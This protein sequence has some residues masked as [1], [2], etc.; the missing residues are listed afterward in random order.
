MAR[1]IVFPLWCY[2]AL[3]GSFPLF[4][5]AS[6]AC[7]ET[8]NPCEKLFF[9]GS[10][11]RNGF[12]SNPFEKGC[13]QTL[14]NSPDDGSLS[15]ATRER[16]S[17]LIRR[18]KSQ[19]RVCNSYDPPEAAAQGLCISHSSSPIKNYRN[20]YKNEEDSPQSE[21]YADYKEI[22]VHSQNWESSFFSAWIIQI[23]LSEILQVPTTI[24]SGTLELSQQNNF[25]DPQA[26]LG[27][28]I[29]ND[30]D[31]F[32]HASEAEG[33][34][35]TK[36]QEDAEANGRGY[37]PCAHAVLEYWNGFYG[38]YQGSLQAGIVEPLKA[39]GAIGQQ[40][41]FGKYKYRMVSTMKEKL[42]RVCCQQHIHSLIYFFLVAH[43]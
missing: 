2:I 43:L 28:G 17:S 18:L 5:E 36:V 19:V 8:Y 37:K 13:L 41:I 40:G 21:L 16:L 26:R 30:W 10:E 9:K 22:R 15:A 7:N 35:C 1:P 29:Q 4:V 11:C 42:D 25:Y 20:H 34:D 33:A 38:D 32:R 14:L 12:C 31:A 27:Y 3:L 6:V 39:L 24:E 23:L